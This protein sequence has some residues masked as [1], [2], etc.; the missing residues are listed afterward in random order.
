MAKKMQFVSA[1]SLLLLSIASLT[2][3]DLLEMRQPQPVK[4]A[5]TVPLEARGDVLSEFGVER[6]GALIN[7]LAKSGIWSV[8]PAPQKQP[9]EALI[10]L[11]WR[12]STQAI[13]RMTPSYFLDSKDKFVKEAV[14]EIIHPESRQLPAGTYVPPSYGGGGGF[15]Q[16]DETCYM[17]VF[18]FVRD[19]QDRSTARVDNANQA[20][21]V[22]E[23]FKRSAKG[24]LWAHSTVQLAGSDLAIFVQESSYSHDRKYTKE[25]VDFVLSELNKTK[26]VLVDGQGKA[27]DLLSEQAL[28]IA[29]ESEIKVAASNVS[30]Y[31]NCGEP[32]ILTLSVIPG[33]EARGKSFNWGTDG[34]QSV[35]AICGWSKDPEQKYFFAIP[36]ILPGDGDARLEQ[37]GFKLTF[38]PTDPARPAR[39]LLTQS[40]AR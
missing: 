21:A 8:V 18:V 1:W 28:K 39:V 2:G 11:P 30:G 31:L 33:A 32:G 14:G 10:H 20:I 7:E 6:R 4:P 16:G 25:A 27:N 5:Y 35:K 15:N 38:Q 34:A 13:L 37:F 40:P 26:S 24:N 9:L 23:S 22:S 12:P 19:N 3:C 17:Q 36:W 29:K